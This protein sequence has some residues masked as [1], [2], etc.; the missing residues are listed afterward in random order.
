[1]IVSGGNFIISRNFNSLLNNKKAKPFP[2][3]VGKKEEVS[4]LKLDSTGSNFIK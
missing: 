1:V 4:M 2:L 3:G